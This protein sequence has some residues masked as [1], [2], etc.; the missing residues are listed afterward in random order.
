MSSRPPRDFDPSA[1]CP[2][3][4]G[5]EDSD[6]A[7]GCCDGPVGVALCYQPDNLPDFDTLQDL[8][9]GFDE[10]GVMTADTPSDEMQ[11]RGIGAEMMCHVTDEVTLYGD[12]PVPGIAGG[13]GS[14]LLTADLGPWPYVYRYLHPMDQPSLGLNPNNW[15]GLSPEAQALG[16][17]IPLL[18]Q[19]SES[20]MTG[21]QLGPR[22]NVHG[23][24]RISVT[25][26]VLSARDY[27]MRSPRGTD[28]VRIDPTG[29]QYLPPNEISRHLD[30][31]IAELERMEGGPY[32]RQ[33]RGRI[34][35]EL[36][37]L[38]R[39]RVNLLSAFREGQIVGQ[40]RPSAAVVG[41]ERFSTIYNSG[42]PTV[43]QRLRLY[44][45][46]GQQEFR[47]FLGTH[48]TTVRV[49]GGVLMVLGAVNT[50]ARI[51]GA[52]PEMRNRVISQEA[53]AWAGGLAG[54]WGGAKAG[55]AIGA[56]VGSF[57][58]VLGTAVG[59]IVG[60]LIGMFIGGA[61]GGWIGATGA[62]YVYTKVA[63]DIGSR[64]ALGHELGGGGYDLQHVY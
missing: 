56:A 53:G 13:T 1:L 5:A 3:A 39:Y 36:T 29:L 58:P 28:L 34:S 63:D 62:D 45:E 2:T 49:T 23:T 32:N 33:T 41:P 15:P 46:I 35:A 42:S 16:R 14:H 50:S 9:A 37:A 38:R 27:M 43:G 21:R 52:S 18:P 4:N 7:T 11:A 30:M 57:V 51:M 55:A 47:S 40:P 10:W 31:R 48:R 24:D 6:C 44:N 20:A 19:G 64:A 60:G 59:A 26:R 8:M 22:G 54:A 12:A 25:D 61:I 17:P